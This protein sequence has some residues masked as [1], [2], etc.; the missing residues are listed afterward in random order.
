MATLKKSCVYIC[1]GALAA[2]ISLASDQKKTVYHVE[3]RG[4]DGRCII[5]SEN[6]RGS[7]HIP[8]HARIVSVTEESVVPPCTEPQTPG[9]SIFVFTDPSNP[10]V[11]VGWHNIQ[12]CVDQIRGT[13]AIYVGE[14]PQYT[15]Y[16]A[17]QMR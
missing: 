13:A 8:G 14:V 4:N 6:D 5:L 17:W 7:V 16:S 3:C 12:A 9:S 1:V 2:T 11:G 15:S 10:D